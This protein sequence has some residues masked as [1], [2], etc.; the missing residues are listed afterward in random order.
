M[1]VVPHEWQDACVFGLAYPAHEEPLPLSAG[2]EEESTGG[3]AASWPCAES[4]PAS[5][6][7]RAPPLLLLLPGSIAEG[8]PE[9]VPS[10][11]GAGS[12][13][14]PVVPTAHAE[15]ARKSDK[16]SCFGCSERTDAMVP[17]RL[18]ATCS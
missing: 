16:T 13:P 12:A 10:P 6:E 14:S 1:C 8:P 7:R 3:C 11:P 5:P 17:K 2:G 4:A 18:P 15:Q 9:L